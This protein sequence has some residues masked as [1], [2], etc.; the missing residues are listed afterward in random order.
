LTLSNFAVFDQG[1]SFEGCG[2]K[3]NQSHDRD[4]IVKGSNSQLGKHPWHAALFVFD[5]EKNKKDFSCGGSLVS[6]TVVVTGEKKII[7][8]RII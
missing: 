1:E 2:I 3:K 4:Y 8:L 5:V 7:L 6:E